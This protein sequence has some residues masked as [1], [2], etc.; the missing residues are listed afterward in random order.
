M[1]EISQTG[2]DGIEVSWSVA[3]AYADRVDVFMEMLHDERL[4]LAAIDSPLWLLG[5]D[6]KEDEKERFLAI[7]RFAAA[8]GAQVVVAM[9][10][11]KW[12]D[13]AISPEEWKA[14]VDFA[15]EV[16]AA[17][18]EMGIKLTFHPEVD[19]WI[20]TR[21]EI[22]SFLDDT[23]SS[24]VGLCIDTAQ[25]QHNRINPA[26]FFLQIHDRVH[27]IHLKDYIKN[28]NPYEKRLRPL[29]RGE[30]DFKS[31]VRS[32]DAKDYNG[33]VVGE[34][35]VPPELNPNPTGTASTAFD[36][37]IHALDLGL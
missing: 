6:S 1:H 34:Y 27:H 17:V 24:A 37:C 26:N 15:N 25:F 5:P 33:W 16:G 28:R 11:R 20:D 22:A 29:G 8:V 7:G 9:A 32:L 35:D 31:I 21:K 3:E 19:T 4:E 13:V 2:Y 30:V 12:P 14:M 10:P 18:E 23:S 36:Y